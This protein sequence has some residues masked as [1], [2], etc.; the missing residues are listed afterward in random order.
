MQL[1]KIFIFAG[2]FRGSRVS[3]SAPSG[4]LALRSEFKSMNHGKAKGN[5]LVKANNF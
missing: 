1:S 2:V 5:N 4:R 3:W